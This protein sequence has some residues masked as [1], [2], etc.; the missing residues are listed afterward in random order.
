MLFFFVLKDKGTIDFK[1]QSRIK[2][3]LDRFHYSH[4]SKVY[5]VNNHII[6]S[7]VSMWLHICLLLKM[8]FT[9]YKAALN[10]SLNNT[11]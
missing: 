8:L 1:K 6:A 5:F 2:K 9:A 4:C 10:P 11:V 7:S 3:L